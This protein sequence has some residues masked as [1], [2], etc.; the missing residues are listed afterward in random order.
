M[1]MQSEDMDTWSPVEKIGESDAGEISAV[2]K[3]G[4]V[5]AVYRTFTNGMRWLVYDVENHQTVSEGQF[6][7]SKGTQGIVSKPNTFLFN[8]DV[9]MAVNSD[10]EVFG[11]NNNYTVYTTIARQQ[12]AMYKVVDGVPKFFRKVNNPTGFNYF[13]FCEAES[14]IS[15]QGSIFVAFCEDRRHLYRRQFANVSFADVTALFVNNGRII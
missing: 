6:P 3:D 1:L 7:V 12:I 13:S 2:Y 14:E 5:Y 4:K 11:P 9:Y 15:G 10:P 8:G